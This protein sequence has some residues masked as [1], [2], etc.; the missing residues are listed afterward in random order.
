MSLKQPDGSFIVSNYGEV[1][2]RYAGPPLTELIISLTHRCQGH[3]LS[4]CSCTPARHCHPGTRRRDCSLHCVLPNLRRGLL[5]RIAPALRGRRVPSTQAQSRR[6][7]RGIHIL[8]ACVVGVAEA[9]RPDGRWRGTRGRAP[10][11]ALARAHA[12]VGGR[13]WRVQGTDEQARRWVLLM[14][15]RRCICAAGSAGGIQHPR[16]RAYR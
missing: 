3:L 10:A 7:S 14:V 6:G 15:G 12:R 16:I 1:D 5:F 2:V 11:V 8:R 4:S 9:I 13:A